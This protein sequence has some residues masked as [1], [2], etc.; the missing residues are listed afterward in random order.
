MENASVEQKTEKN[1]EKDEEKKEAADADGELSVL[2]AR[3]ALV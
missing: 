3:W 1:K 2:L